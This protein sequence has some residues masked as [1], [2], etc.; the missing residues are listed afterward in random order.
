MFHPN[1]WVLQRLR[2]V[3]SLSPGV[4]HWSL[5]FLTFQGAAGHQGAVGSPG[6]AGPRVST[7]EGEYFK[8]VYTAG[9]YFSIKTSSSSFL[10]GPVGPHGPPGKDG[11]S[12]HP[13]PI[14]PPGPRGNRGERGSE[15][16]MHI[17]YDLICC[18]TM[19]HQHCI[20]CKLK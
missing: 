9:I 19:F 20:V 14:G 13:G 10:K 1:H 18:N 3:H 6:P 11:S 5:F 17:H 2:T 16:K 12:G 4:L 8:H 15:V 7:L